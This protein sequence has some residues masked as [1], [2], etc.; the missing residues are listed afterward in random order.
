M[1][2]CRLCKYLLVKIR[3]VFRKEEDEIVKVK[4]VLLPFE[5]I[6]NAL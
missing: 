3:R 1:F 4:Y 6:E 2:C 5:N